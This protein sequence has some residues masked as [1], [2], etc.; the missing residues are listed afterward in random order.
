MARPLTLDEST[1]ERALDDLSVYVLP[2]RTTRPVLAIDEA[3]D[4]ER[5]GFGG[6]YMSERL[7][8]K[9][10]GAVCGA[11]AASTSRVRVGPA[12]VHQGTRHPLTTAAMA[13][14]LQSMTDGRFVL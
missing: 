13:A 5:L 11:I 10:A 12:L 8:L 1:V 14:T 6:V 9:E 7:D 3:R 4:A 2:G